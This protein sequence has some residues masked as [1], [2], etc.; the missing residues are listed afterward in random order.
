MP[1]AR[2][3]Y[4]ACP[5]HTEEI[6]WDLLDAEKN[7]GIKLTESYAMS[8]GSAVSGFYFSHPDSRYFGV[9]E[10]W[11]DQAKDY[12]ERKGMSLEEAEKWL[13]PNLAYDPSSN[14]GGKLAS[15]ARS[16]TGS[17]RSTTLRRRM[18]REEEETKDG[19][20]EVHDYRGRGL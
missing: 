11:R 4:P 1:P 16:L 10:I 17:R 19:S 12:A 13:A 9:A 8:P 14:N 18:L 15:V 7:S 3:G 2:P 20:G 5:E 6:L